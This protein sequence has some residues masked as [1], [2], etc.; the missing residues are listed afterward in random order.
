M[1]LLG[2]VQEVLHNAELWR[3]GSAVGSWTSGPQSDYPAEQAE[4]HPIICLN[5]LFDGV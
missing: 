3:R 2:G 1:R 4:T 5:L